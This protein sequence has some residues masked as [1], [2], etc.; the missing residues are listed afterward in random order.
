MNQQAPF[1]RFR[2]TDLVILFVLFLGGR[3]EV[4]GFTNGTYSILVI[5]DD[6]DP[7]PSIPHFLGF[8][9]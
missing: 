1:V 6:S 8:E 5:D 9:Y 2:R 4:T 7:Y 3:G